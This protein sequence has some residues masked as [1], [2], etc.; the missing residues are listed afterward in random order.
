MEAIAASRAIVVLIGA[1]LIIIGVAFGGY[2]IMLALLPRLGGVGAAAAT[3]AVLLVF[4]LCYLAL[5]AWRNSRRPM[6]MPIAAALTPETAVLSALAT[7][8]RGNP[9]LA[10][11]LAAL[12]GAA[13]V[14]L[15]PPRR[16][17]RLGSE[18]RS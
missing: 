18:T 1:A 9:L 3:A 10:I 6:A 14:W 7:T 5:A 11:A 15:N 12:F 16:R 8:A 2:A 13:S 17:T 4:P